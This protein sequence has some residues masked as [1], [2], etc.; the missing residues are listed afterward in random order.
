MPKKV[1]CYRHDLSTVF[2]VDRVSRF[3]KG[4]VQE[5]SFINDW[6]CKLTLRTS[7]VYRWTYHHRRSG[8]EGLRSQWVRG[9]VPEWPKWRPV[10][11]NESR[12]GKYVLPFDENQRKGPCVKVV[13]GVSLNTGDMLNRKSSSSKDGRRYRDEH[14][15]TPWC[16]TAPVSYVLC[17]L[18]VSLN[19]RSTQEI[20]FRLHPCQDES[21][22]L[23]DSRKLQESSEFP[24]SHSLPVV[25]QWFT[26]IRLFL[27]LTTQGVEN[28]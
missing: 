24:V 28:P 16:L 4:W 10:A 23:G 15:P 22:S 18:R 12:T 20:L 26:P 1:W 21:S 19:P 14:Y 13:R 8:D 5:M 27:I 2:A 7:S 9:R 11:G 25:D 6:T 3:Y 17:S